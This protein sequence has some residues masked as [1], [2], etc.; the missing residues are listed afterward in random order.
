ME[1]LLGSHPNQ[2]THQ[3]VFAVVF[4][5]KSLLWQMMM[6]NYI[7][8]RVAITSAAV[9]AGVFV[10][11]SFSKTPA[12][13]ELQTINFSSNIVIVVACVRHYLWAL[14]FAHKIKQTAR[15]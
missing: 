7:P 13:Y 3:R 5:G 6:V 8:L 9:T 4:H 15:A 11:M 12:E 1:N 2:M 14:S 10:A